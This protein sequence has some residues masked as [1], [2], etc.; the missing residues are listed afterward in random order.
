M[1]DPEP[2]YSIDEAAR[3]AGER[4]SAIRRLIRD[5]DF[6]AFRD[7]DGNLRVDAGELSHWLYACRT[8]GLRRWQEEIE[9]RLEESASMKSRAVID[10]LEADVVRQAVRLSAVEEQL[11]RLSELFRKSENIIS[12]MG[13]NVSEGF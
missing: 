6:P 3:I 4:P 13:K 1:R 12:K 8:G 10:R 9:R 11:A 5:S 2:T 7:E